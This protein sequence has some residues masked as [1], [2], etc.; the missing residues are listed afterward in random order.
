M[1]VALQRLRERLRSNALSFDVAFGMARA[2]SCSGAMHIWYAYLRRI[3]LQRAA[4]VLGLRS[5]LSAGWRALCIHA[6]EHQKRRR[7]GRSS[8]ERSRQWAEWLKRDEAKPLWMP[9][10]TRQSQCC[11]AHQHHHDGGS[12]A[13]W[14]YPVSH[15][16]GA[17]TSPEA[18][19]RRSLTESYRAICLEGPQKNFGQI[20]ADKHTR[21]KHQREAVFPRETPLFIR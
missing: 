4:T 7:S 16:R 21:K 15:R 11:T 14:T 18:T 19:S 10:L 3:M 1:R 5:L 13:L 6:D 2:L 12:R 9:M 17:R 8:L 20:K